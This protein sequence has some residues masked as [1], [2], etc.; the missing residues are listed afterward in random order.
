MA[1]VALSAPHAL[2]TDSS[3]RMLTG[4]SLTEARARFIRKFDEPIPMEKESRAS[5][6]ASCA[7]LVTLAGEGHVSTFR[8]TPDINFGMAKLAECHALAMALRAKPARTSFLPPKFDEGFLKSLPTCFSAQ[9]SG[10]SSWLP[11][12]RLKMLSGLKFVDENPGVVFNAKESGPERLVF[13]DGRARL[14]FELWFLGD[15]NGDGVEDLGLVGFDN[16]GGSL[17]STGFMVFTRHSP[18]EVFHEIGS[19]GKIWQSR[20][21]NRLFLRGEIAPDEGKSWNTLKYALELSECNRKELRRVRKDFKSIYDRS[22]HALAEAF[23]SAVLESCLES[24]KRHD[25]ELLWL[26]SDAALAAWKGGEKDVCLEL[27]DAA[28]LSRYARFQGKKV[29]SALEFN[30]KKCGE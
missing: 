19:N 15:V 16:G 14:V 8:S 5:V 21:D 6:A 29:Y 12:C 11:R 7:D 27:T 23:A 24:A 26:R 4:I 17:T 3:P 18:T 25:E 13:D 10:D 22:H 20:Q 2:S 1:C 9:L 28:A 30:R